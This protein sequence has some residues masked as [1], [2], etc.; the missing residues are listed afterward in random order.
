MNPNQSRVSLSL[1]LL[2]AA[3]GGDAPSAASTTVTPSPQVQKLVLTSDPGAAISVK[4]AK[5][6]GT[7]DRAVVVGRIAKLSPGNAA[8]TLADASMPYCGEKNPDDHCP[9]PWD[10]CCE[11]K[12]TITGNSMFV[13]A[14]GS[15]GNT[16][17]T[18]ALP[19]LRLLDLVKVTGKLAKDEH[20]NVSIVADGFFRTERPK[21]PDYVKWPQ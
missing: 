1:I 6:T 15:D 12:D 21:L 5:A 2:L 4:D 3:C 19:D 17:A 11:S 20:G 9:T 13:E 14:K 7:K 18:P 8:F 16:L 10:Y